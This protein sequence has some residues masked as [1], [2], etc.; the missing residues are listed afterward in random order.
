MISAASRLF[1]VVLI[2]LLALKL[3]G[4][5]AGAQP[6]WISLSVGGAEGALGIA[7]VAGFRSRETLFTAA[8]LFAAMVIFAFVDTTGGACG[9]MGIWEADRRERI[10]VASILGGTSSLLSILLARREAT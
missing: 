9:C 1:G 2:A 5:R 10:V 7:L 8:I 4:L 6:D 3:L